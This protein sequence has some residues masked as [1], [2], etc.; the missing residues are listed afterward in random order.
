VDDASILVPHELHLIYSI[1]IVTINALDSPVLWL[2]PIFY[3]DKEELLMC[4]K[5]KLEPEP[6]KISLF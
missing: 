6:E 2:E 4:W 1:S 3:L 5:P